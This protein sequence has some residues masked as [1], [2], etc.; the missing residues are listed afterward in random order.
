MAHARCSCGF[1]E[2][3]DE[4][5]SDHLYEMF[6]PDDGKAPDGRVHLEGEVGLYCMCG[7]GGSAAKLDEHFLD[8]FTA[9]DP[10]GRDGVSHQLA[11]GDASSRPY[12]QLECQRPSLLS[13]LWTSIPGSLSLDP[14]ANSGSS[15]PA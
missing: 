5:I 1:T 11:A 6:A 12:E 15:F 9:T 13:N 10:V 14:P 4:K 3:G 2:A 8:V 7:A